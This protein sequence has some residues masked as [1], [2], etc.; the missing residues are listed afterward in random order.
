MAAKPAGGGE[1]EIGYAVPGSKFDQLDGTRAD[2]LL[3][4]GRQVGWLGDWLA[5]PPSLR[6]ASGPRWVRS[7]YA[8]LSDDQA[9]PS[10]TTLTQEHSVARQT[11][12][13]ALRV[14]ETEGLVYR[15]PGLGYYVR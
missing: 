15:V 10:I 13:K 12:A 9:T 5:H 14:L 1:G 11:A 8:G 4:G 6:P 3:G 2:L 7:L